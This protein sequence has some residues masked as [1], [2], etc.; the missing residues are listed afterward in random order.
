M[1]LFDVAIGTMLR[2][3][4]GWTSFTYRGYRYDLYDGRFVR[5]ANVA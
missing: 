2:I 5:M 1:R 3:P 4:N